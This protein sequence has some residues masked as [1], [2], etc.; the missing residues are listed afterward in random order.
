MAWEY[1]NTQEFDERYKIVA[2]QLPEGLSDLDINCGQPRFKN[3]Y[4]YSKE[5]RN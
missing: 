4:K 5:F 1:L 2:K 3:Y